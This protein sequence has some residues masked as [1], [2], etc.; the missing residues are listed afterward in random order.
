MDECGDKVDLSSENLSSDEVDQGSN[1]EDDEEDSDSKYR[2]NKKTDELTEL[3]T[4]PS[5]LWRVSSGLYSTASGAVGMG[6]GSIKWAAGKSYNVGSS[7]V[8][9]VKVPSMQSL[10]RK[11]KKE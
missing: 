11:N 2:S 10:K 8:S 7:V 4:Q 6:V 9:H 5:M 3:V 1:E